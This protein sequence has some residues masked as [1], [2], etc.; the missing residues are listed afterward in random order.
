MPKSPVSFNWIELQKA[1]S[2]YQQSAENRATQN[3][4][5]SRNSDR[6]LSYSDAVAKAGPSVVSVK[7]FFKGKARPARDGREGDVL[8]DFSINVGSGVI[9][10]KDGYI[11][12]NYHVV[13][14]SF[15]V[16][17]HF[18][19]GRHKF[20]DIVGVDQ[21]NDIAVLK[22][23]IK[24]PH[25]ADLGRSSLVRTGDIVMAIG[26]PF[27]VFNNSVTSG[28]ISSVDLDA[29]DPRI[30]TDAA[31]NYGNSGG[32]L[33]NTMGQ[34]IAISSSKLS[35][36]RSSE[37]S[38]S[39]G[40]PIDLVKEVF[41]EIQLHGRVIRNWLGA[42][43]LQLK[44][45]GH[46]QLDPGIEFGTGLLVYMVEK[47]SPSDLAGLKSGDFLIRFDG[48]DVKNMVQF[49]KLYIAIPIGKDVRIEILRDKKPVTLQLKLKERPLK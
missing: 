39:F 43:L 2:F 34:V 25:V 24:T 41:M 13:A 44:R 21:Q 7:A 22:V 32:A 36:K 28:I 46:A 49:K 12:T 42:N 9:F 33:I 47:E 48:D 38:I 37:T 23:D 31:I 6:V 11:V 27:G 17:V 10:D 26:T 19:D 18:S 8:V 1:W 30:Q 29:L 16:A 5:N 40:I 3:D 35:A 20:A 45:P 14:G 4:Q 15:R